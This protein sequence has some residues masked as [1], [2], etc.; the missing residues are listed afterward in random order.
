EREHGTAAGPM[1]DVTHNLADAAEADV[2]AI[3]L[4][5][6]SRMPERPLSPRHDGERNV[7]TEGAQ[8]FA[9][10]C[11]PCHGTV[12]PTFSGAA[13]PLELTTSLNAPD[14][15]NAIHIVMEGL[16]PEAGDRGALM[17]GFASGLTDAQVAA[18]VDYLHA[19]YTDRAA[20]QEVAAQVA[21]IRRSLE[22]E[23]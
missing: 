16:R 23:P 3:A 13:I 22:G 1:A 11:A 7:S 6:A 10:A 20:W 14:P 19:R 5:I 15:R 2:R 21:A 17:P 12:P 18:L 8:I 4:Y 9:G